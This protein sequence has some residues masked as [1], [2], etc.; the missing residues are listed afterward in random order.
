MQLEGDSVYRASLLDETSHYSRVVNLMFLENDV[1][2][3]FSTTRPSVVEPLRKR[4]LVLSL[5][6][7]A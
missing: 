6:R 7:S 1:H 4:P 2:C 3:S 5:Y